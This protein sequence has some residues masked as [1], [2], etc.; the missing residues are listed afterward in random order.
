M[1][2][3][4]NT[5][6][7][8]PGTKKGKNDLSQNNKFCS[9]LNLKRLPIFL[10]REIVCAANRTW[11]RTPIR[12]CRQPLSRVLVFKYIFFCAIP[13]FSLRL[14][15]STVERSAALEDFFFSVL[16]GGRV[17]QRRLRR[18]RSLTVPALV[19]WKK[20]KQEQ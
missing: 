19:A 7:T 1:A 15:Y 18:R 20:K 4:Y 11:I 17:R 8:F 2:Y 3:S 16:G 13:T 9:I 12:A 10:V 6:M 5:G 14:C